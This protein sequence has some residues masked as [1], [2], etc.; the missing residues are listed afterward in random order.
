MKI[1]KY[2][3]RQAFSYTDLNS[4]FTGLTSETLFLYAWYQ[5]DSFSKMA[6]NS[7]S[8]MFDDRL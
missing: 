3:V 4:V 8:G 2:H 1:L 7:D 5:S 6:S